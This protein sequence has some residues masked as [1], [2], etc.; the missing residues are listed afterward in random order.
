MNLYKHLMGRCEE[1]GVRLS[2]TVPSDKTRGSGHK[3]KL[4]RFPLNVKKQLIC[5]EGD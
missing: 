5:C 1:E 2:S 4:Q 3:L